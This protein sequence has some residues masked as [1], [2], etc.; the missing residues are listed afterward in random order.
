MSRVPVFLFLTASVLVVV[1]ADGNCECEARIR[2]LERFQWCTA[3]LDLGLISGTEHD[4]AIAEACRKLMFFGHV[5]NPDDPAAEA[6]FIDS[7]M[8]AYGRGPRARSDL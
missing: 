1:I 8:V 6:Q 4:E 7:V 2:R 3:T 5:R